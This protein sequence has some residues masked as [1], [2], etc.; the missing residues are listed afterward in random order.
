MYL[1]FRTKKGFLIYF[2]K[3]MYYL[4]DKKIFLVYHCKINN[5][6]NK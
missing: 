5:L 6:N 3:S 2:S 1:F 4:I